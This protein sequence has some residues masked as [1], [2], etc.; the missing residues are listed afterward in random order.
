MKTQRS[1]RLQRRLG[2]GL[3]TGA[4]LAGGLLSTAMVW[5]ADDGSSAIDQLSAMLDGDGGSGTGALEG[6]AGNEKMIRVRAADGRKQG[7]AE[8]S[9]GTGDGTGLE[10]AIRTKESRYS[11]D[12][13]VAFEVKGNKA[14]HL[15][16]F[17]VDPRTERVVTILPNQKQTNRE[18]K[19]PGDNRWRKVPNP[20][21]EFYADEAG[22]ER[23]VMVAS[24]KYL[25]V[26]KL[27]NRGGTK[28]LGD[29]LFESTDALVWLEESLN[30]AYP[31]SAEKGMEPKRIRV[32]DGG[33]NTRKLPKDVVIDE[34]NLRI[35]P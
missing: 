34:F 9:G 16:L 11:V 20:G 21:V 26:D 7:S 25:D 18:L 31:A 2:R 19:Y 17:N 10:V 1:N 3:L 22:N 27:L 24:E 4:L 5:A 28:A 6:V 8:R 30:E 14:F 29:D 23:I 33:E 15:Y 32:R 35:L 13:P 12:E